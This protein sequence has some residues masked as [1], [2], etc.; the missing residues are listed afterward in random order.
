MPHEFH[1]DTDLYF[2]QQR[3]N[4]LGSIV[5]FVAPHVGLGPETRVLEIGCGAGGVLAAFAASGARVTG[6]DLHGPSIEYAR[7]RFEAVADGAAWS[8]DL[9]DIYEVAPAELDGPFDLVVMK[10]TIEH[11]HDQRRL[12]DRLGAFLAPAGR[13]FLAFP[14]W[15]MPFGGHQQICDNRVLM[16][17][18]YVHLLPRRAYARLLQ[19]AGES[20]ETIGA[21]LEIKETGIGIDRLERIAG[22]AGYR[23]ADRRLYLVNPMY[24]YRYGIGERVQPDPVA[25]VAGL[26]DLVTTSAYYVLERG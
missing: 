3:E 19:R 25:R 20:R 1:R 4:A 6:V 9:R 24:R 13:L 10:D 17:L 15:R 21:L 11:I 12:F 5:P 8:F 22:A 14:P 7:R 26:R 16:H 2:D 18:P 23:I